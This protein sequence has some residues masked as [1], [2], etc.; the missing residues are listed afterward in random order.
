M[1]LRLNKPE[2]FDDADIS[3]EDVRV[4]LD[5]IGGINRRFGGASVVVDFFRRHARGARFTV[6]DLGT[7]SGDI[8]HAVVRWARSDAKDVSVTALDTNAHCIAY[9]RRRYRSDAIRYLESSA[10]DLSGLGTFDYITASMFF[11]HLADE[12]M[13]SLLRLMDRHARKGFIVNDL[14][15]G[16][17]PYVGAFLLASASGKQTIVNDAPLSVRRGFREPDLVRLAEAAGLNNF[18]VRRK[19]FYRIALSCVK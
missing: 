9:A 5:F 4:S 2:R 1:R 16:W 7:G 6:L 15:R 10:F 18:E 13:V 11:H 8:P 17:V 19:P 3:E 14:Y 12:E